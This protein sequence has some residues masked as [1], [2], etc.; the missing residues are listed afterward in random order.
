M[1]RLSDLSVARVRDEVRKLEKE[2][3]DLGDKM[4]SLQTGV[5]RGN[6]R[7]DQFKLLMARPC[8]QCIDAPVHT[9]PPPF[10]GRSSPI[11]FL[12]LALG[13]TSKH[14]GNHNA[15]PVLVD[16]VG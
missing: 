8:S 2:E 1:K 13:L 6:E 3:V 16:G 11:S 12:V 10:P 7:L 4:T 15:R 9:H 5:H 14:A